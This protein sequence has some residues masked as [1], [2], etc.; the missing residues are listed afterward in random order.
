MN[1]ISRLSFALV[2]TLL[3]AVQPLSAQPAAQDTSARREMLSEEDLIRSIR[4]N[5]NVFGTVYREISL[6]YVDPVSPE[7]FI[8][9][10]INGMLGSLDPYTEYYDKPEETDD[11]RIMTRGK[12]GGIGIQIG[13]RGQ[14]RVL[15]IISPMEGTP[16]WRLGLRAG[17]QIIKINGESTKGFSTSDAAKRMRGIPGT[18]VM[19]TIRRYGA[20]EPLEYTITREEIKV[21]DVSYAGMI[22]PGIGY[23]RLTRFSRSAGEQVRA[24]VEDLKAQGLRE[25]IL[26]L[27]SN[28]GGLLPEA[29]AVAEN[30]LEPGDPVVSTRGRLPA[31]NREYKAQQD[32]ALP[33]DVPLAILVNE[34]TASASEIVAGAIQDLD[35][36]VI[37]GMP[38]F[39]KGLVQSVVDFRDG[40]ALKLTTAMYYTPSGRLIQKTDYFRDNTAILAHNEELESDTLSY[41]VGGRP[42]TAHGGITPDFRVE[43]PEVGELI[44]ELWRQGTFFD[45][46]GRYHGE[47]PD[48]TSWAVDDSV[49]SAFLAYLDETGFTFRTEAERRLEGL[50]K[51]AEENGYDEDFLKELADLEA[52]VQREK[53]QMYADEEQQ[54][55]QR[56]E[57]ELAQVLAGNAGRVQASLSFDPQIRKAVEVVSTG[58]LYEAT[59][60][61]LMNEEAEGK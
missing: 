45:F 52:A 36:G 4:R 31:S 27:R 46:A 22:E 59:L 20:E 26:D 39:G 14:D 54:I 34:G 58:D 50:R 7:A 55:R 18:D 57:I 2:I 24:A 16:A 17:D 10:G 44:V 33:A 40:T 60:A 38:T 1:R 3:L 15:T 53:R 43:M 29:V 28:P 41:T 19:I 42:V 5:I 21:Q 49:Y 47:H 11:L 23:I 12:Y 61:G 8:R 13:L 35:R 48:M 9:A 51:L 32:P 37:I 30:F 25:L 56:I 6:K